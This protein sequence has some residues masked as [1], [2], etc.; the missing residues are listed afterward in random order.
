MNFFKK[1][2]DI[3]NFIMIRIR[4]YFDAEI[5][6]EYQRCVDYAEATGKEEGL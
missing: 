3:K 4:C 1:L 5:E 2:K 6:D